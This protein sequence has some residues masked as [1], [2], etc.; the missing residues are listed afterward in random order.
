[1]LN[2]PKPIESDPFI[3]REEHYS[4][5]Q[6]GFCNANLV[7]ELDPEEVN[8]DVWGTMAKNKVFHTSS[9]GVNG[10][11]G[12]SSTVSSTKAGASSVKMLSVDISMVKNSKRLADL[13]SSNEDGW[14]GKLSP[15][16]SKRQC[17]SQASTGNSFLGFQSVFSFL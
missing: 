12:V 14:K 1:M 6:P 9:G 5:N 10:K 8:R 4:E 17:C 13:G 15:N 11:S 7:S 16:E 3:W 2:T